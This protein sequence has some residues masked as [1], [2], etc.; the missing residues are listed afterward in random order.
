MNF[1]PE[2]VTTKPED[3]GVYETFRLIEGVEAMSG[4]YPGPRLGDLQDPKKVTPEEFQFIL[5]N[6]SFRYKKL[7][8]IWNAPY[9]YTSMINGKKH[10]WIPLD[11]LP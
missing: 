11:C 7:L 9:R 3:R 1:F 10:F 6:F 4:K 5:D 2:T 8:E